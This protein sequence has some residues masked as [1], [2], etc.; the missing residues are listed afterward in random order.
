MTPDPGRGR[1]GRALLD[2]LFVCVVTFVAVVT[3]PLHH[4]AAWMFGILALCG[5]VTGAVVAGSVGV[6]LAVAVV[7]GALV[8][9]PVWLLLLVLGALVIEWPAFVRSAM[10]FR[11]RDATGRAVARV[12]AEPDREGVWRVASVTAW[13][14]GDGRGTALMREVLREADR[15]RWVLELTATT[16]RIRQWYVDL[17]FAPVD[18]RRLRRDPATGVSRRIGQS[19]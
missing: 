11:H 8:A 14:R 13:P 19:S 6:P 1:L 2:A 5:A 3:D 10:V 18:G 9:L 4:R 17:G 7:L 16:S 12:T 15:R